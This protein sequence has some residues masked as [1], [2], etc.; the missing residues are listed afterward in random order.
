MSVADET[1]IP[2]LKGKVAVVTG[3]GNNIG[4]AY[5]TSL[6]GH[7][8][9]VVVADINGAA[10]KEVASELTAAGH[11]A[12]AAEVDIAD[13]E[14]TVRLADT[15]GEAYGHLDILVNNAGLWKGVEFE[16]AH[17]IPVERWQRMQD[18]NYT[19][20]W[21]VTRAMVPLLIEAGG[22]AIV[23]QSSVG[24]YLAGPGMAHYAASKGAVNA[25]T[26]A[27]ARDLGEYGIRVNAIAPGVIANEATLSNVPEEMLDALEVQQCL[28]RKGSHQD[29]LGPLLFL[30]SD[31]SAFISGQ[32]LVVDGGLVLLG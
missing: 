18:V 14:A 25:L 29:L 19:G 10:A 4:R 9:S 27:L 7:G 23:N 12:L 1:V 20:T 11:V 21:L 6:A 31:L 26:K 5:A 22:G 3:A 8:V 24:A 16:E 30:C 32:V 15:V 28:K 13:P 2:G 17:E